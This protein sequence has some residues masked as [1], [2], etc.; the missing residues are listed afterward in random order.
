MCAVQQYSVFEKVTLSQVLNTDFFSRVIDNHEL[1]WLARQNPHLLVYR[2]TV[3]FQRQ[4]FMFM[5][6]RPNRRG[7]IVFLLEN[8]QSQ[9]LLH[10]KPFFPNG[11][12]RLLSGGINTGE[13]VEETLHREVFEETGFKINNGIC[14]ALI[15]FTLQYDTLSMPFVT[16]LYHIRGVNGAPV[17]HDKSEKISGFC[18][19]DIKDLDDIYRQLLQLSDNWQDWGL[20]RAL[21][22]K[23]FYETLCPENGELEL[24][25]V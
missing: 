12:Y 24:L 25:P 7:E 10:T 19:I 21:P 15:F 23:I 1:D 13:A 2:A 6:N 22:H 16:Y 18:W 17:V 14:H 8:E 9:A 3:P 11:V 4:H 20:F 5:Y